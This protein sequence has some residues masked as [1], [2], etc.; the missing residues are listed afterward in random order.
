MVELVADGLVETLGGADCVGG[1][2]GE[3]DREDV[4]VTELEA[5]VEAE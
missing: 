3:V 5:P 2:E 1:T 4:L